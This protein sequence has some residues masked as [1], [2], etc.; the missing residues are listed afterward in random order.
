MKYIEQI[1][2]YLLTF[3]VLLSIVLTLMIWNYKPEYA[4]IEEA[5]VDETMIGNTKQL[6]DVL[7]P[8]RILFR[9]DDQFYGTVS[10]DVIQDVYNKLSTWDAHEIDLINS[11]LSDAKMNEMLRWNNRLTLF[12]NDEVPLQVFSGILSFNEK[13][14]PDASFTRLILDWTDVSSNNQLQLL[15]LN[16]EKRILFRSTIELPNSI[17][18]MEEIVDPIKEYQAYFEVERDSSLSLYVVQ[19]AMESIQYTYF[20]DKTSPDIFKNILFGDP[21]IVQRN[22]ESTQAE[23]YT[24]G[25]SLMTV[26]T[27]NHILNYVYPP[28]ESIAPIPSARLLF[29]SFDFIN[30]HGGFTAD[31]RFSSMNVGKHVIEYQ[32]FVQ[33][34]PI[35]SSTTTSR[36]ITTWGENRIFRYRRPYYS[37]DP[38]NDIKTFRTMKQLAS[39]EEVIEYLKNK[40]VQP[41]DEIDEIIIGY[42]LMQDTKQGLF[43]LEPSWFIISNNVWTRISPEQLGG[44]NDGLE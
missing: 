38:S 35:Y 26:D 29:D 23:K 15:F 27:Q 21:G 42:H 19:E 9:Q 3:L 28:A 40:E 5:Q 44:A 7:K 1:K 17:Q 22:I 32:L 2:S 31:F 41:F 33:D 43:L 16:T 8:Y 20:M 11:N 13:E 30:D 12:F 39:G 14:L 24:D 6:Q 25:T 37:I 10:N 4:F 36:I 18:F 34:Y